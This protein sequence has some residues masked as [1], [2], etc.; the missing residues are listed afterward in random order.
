MGRGEALHVRRAPGHPVSPVPLAAAGPAASIVPVAVHSGWGPGELPPARAAP[1][2]PACGAPAGGRGELVHPGGLAAP[3]SRGGEAGLRW[4][5]PRG[6]CWGLAV[7]GAGP[8]PDTLG[9]GQGAASHPLLWGPTC[10]PVRAGKGRRDPGRP[11]EGQPAAGPGDGGG[12]GGVAGWGSGAGTGSWSPSARK[13]VGPRAALEPSWAGGSEPTGPSGGRAGTGPPRGWGLAAPRGRPGAVP[14]R[15][16]PSAGA[17]GLLESS[18]PNRPHVRA[19]GG[20]VPRAG[21]GG[22]GGP[23]GWAWGCSREGPASARTR[24]PSASRPEPAW[25]RSGLAPG[26]RPPGSDQSLF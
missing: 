10:E 1:A 8:L 23:G 7:P 5:P 4:G 26:P 11:H 15:V 6:P 20:P 12:Q 18:F 2:G 19:P 22:R 17:R 3:R 24:R 16:P 9:W 14:V 13:K 25:G 21:R